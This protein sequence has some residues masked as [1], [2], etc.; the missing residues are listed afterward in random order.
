MFRKRSST[1]EVKFEHSKSILTGVCIYLGLFLVHFALEI[2][3]LIKVF[4]FCTRE[5]IFLSITLSFS[6]EKRAGDAHL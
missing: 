4:F 1:N 6:H 2:L 5:R 3:N